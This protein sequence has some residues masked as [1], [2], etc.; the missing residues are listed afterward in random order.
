MS[1]LN[2]KFEKNIQSNKFANERLPSNFN[3][4]A[5]S[6]ENLTFDR[7]QELYDSI[8]YTIP[9]NGKLS[10][11]YIIEQSY[12]LINDEHN[13]R[14]DNLIEQTINQLSNSEQIFLNK[15]QP[16]KEHPIYADGE[17]LIAG[18]PAEQQQFQGMDT[19]YIMQEGVKRTISGSREHVLYN[20]I[21][22]LLGKPEDFTQLNYLSI[23][24]LNSIDDG[25]PIQNILSLF[26]QDLTF[27]NTQLYQRLPF[28]EA[29]IS[30]EGKPTPDVDGLDD[31]DYIFGEGQ[32][33]IRYIVDDQLGDD[34]GVE[35]KELKLNKGETKSII[36]ARDTKN[37]EAQFS[38]SSLYI[39]GDSGI[40]EDFDYD[41][42]YNY[43]FYGNGYDR[44]WGK[45]GYY[46]G[47]VYINN[48]NVKI[49]EVRPNNE[50][51][52]SN[53]SKLKSIYTLSGD[54]EYD[55]VSNYGTRKIY[56]GGNYSNPR[57]GSLNHGSWMQGYFNDL[58]FYYYKRF[59]GT[60]GASTASDFSAGDVTIYGKPILLYKNN[61]VIALKAI[62]FF[63]QGNEASGTDIR[64]VCL[65]TGGG[66]EP[67][68]VFDVSSKKA[69]EDI[70]IFAEDNGEIKYNNIKPEKLMYRGLPTYW[71][72]GYNNPMN[73]ALSTTTNWDGGISAGYYQVT[74]QALAA[75]PNNP[76]AVTFAGNSAESTP[77]NT[78]TTGCTHPNVGAYYLSNGVFPE[79]CGPDDIDPNLPLN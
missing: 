39:V 18:N 71:E 42:Y 15:S 17:F 68:N 41:S 48:S 6:K 14:L 30:C 77:T 35:V 66:Y 64:F 25:P 46:K 72:N 78:G 53:I 33:V 3:E 12:N 24:E 49:R 75:W 73:P 22:K 60:Y 1:T 54:P 61:L 5:K 45:N 29:F 43:D 8:F 58:N 62:V 76:V 44:N 56:R 38:D 36:F 16:R 32:C 28:Y 50:K 63:N 37:E 4:V 27:E 11:S 47:I 19:V 10:H 34:I 40:P 23:E 57:Y 79:G 7:I 74:A 13:K 21:R 31:A 26:I 59:V 9:K 70:G 67:G 55:E 51:L 20:T 65:K 69:Y 2:I 52:Y